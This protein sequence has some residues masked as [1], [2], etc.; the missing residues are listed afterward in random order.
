VIPEARVFFAKEKSMIAF[1]KAD[2]RVVDEP[3][4]YC[5]VQDQPESCEIDVGRTERSP[6]AMTAMLCVASAIICLLV[7]LSWF[8]SLWA[9]VWFFSSA[10]L[11][12]V[13]GIAI[14]LAISGE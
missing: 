11:W 14:G 1:A 12:C 2:P 10:S 7:G 8:P 4:P 9:W 13:M 6:Q 3:C 5:Q